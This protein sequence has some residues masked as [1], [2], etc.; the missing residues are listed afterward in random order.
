M[1]I[2]EYLDVLQRRKWVI[3][4][5][6]LITVTIAVLGTI[7]SP[8][9]YVATATVR[10]SPAPGTDFGYADYLY[11]DR[12]RNTYARMATSEPVLEQVKLRLSLKA[13]PKAEQ[14]EANVIKG[15]ELI[16]LRAKASEPAYARDVANALAEVFVAQGNALSSANKASASAILGEELAQLEKELL[17]MQADYDD[18]LKQTPLDP[19]RV[20]TLARNIRLKE[21]VQAMLLNRYEQARIADAMG[22]NV[23]SVIEPAGMP[24]TP[25]QPRP[26]VN[27]AGGIAMGLMAGLMLAFLFENL[28]TTIYGPDQV[29]AI[30]GVPVFGLVPGAD[31]ETNSQHEIAPGYR[32]V[33]TN[34]A[35]AVGKGARTFL[36]TSVDSEANEAHIT[37]NIAISMAEAGRSVIIVEADPRE[38]ELHRPS[39]I[40]G[41]PEPTTVGK[42][43]AEAHGDALSSTAVALNQET[44]HIEL[45]RVCPG[46]DGFWTR[47]DLH[48]TS[49][50]IQS[51]S[52]QADVVLV[53]APSVLAAPEACLL[54]S[55]A[56][57]VLLVIRLGQ[58][59]TEGVQQALKQLSNVGAE[60]IGMILSDAKAA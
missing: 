20:S 31:G 6:L 55:T 24:T 54:S 25:A 39:R 28:D 48:R 35:S 22:T 33:Q 60:L 3:F 14:I 9:I 18:L 52:G 4:T 50:L 17:Q 51:L 26:I 37:E 29:E 45:V 43:L 47:S 40:T 23:A 38:Q 42:Q 27:I 58:T 56:D 2:R 36:V 21:N 15:T 59:T 16:E 12:L 46:N 8:P 7:F 53:N 13:R 34:L 57:G 11:S 19:E 1:E 44:P 30:S 32:L 10:I 41:E 5:T 49:K